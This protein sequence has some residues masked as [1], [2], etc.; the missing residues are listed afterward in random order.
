VNVRSVAALGAVLAILVLTVRPTPAQ[1]DAPPSFRSGVNAVRV[2]VIVTSGDGRPIADLEASD[3]EVFEDGTPQTI[4]SFEVVRVDGSTSFLQYAP[5]PIRS[6]ADEEVEAGRPD[7]GL[8]L[9]YFNGL[10]M[11]PNRAEQILEPLAQFVR[12]LPPGDMVGVMDPLTP[13]SAVMLT[14]DR[15]ATVAA[16]RAQADMAARDRRERALLNRESIQPYALDRGIEAASL[17]LASLREGRQA[18]ILI[19]SSAPS[20]QSPIFSDLVKLLNANNTAVHVVDP[21]GLVPG[22]SIFRGSDLQ[23]LAERTGGLAVT[24]TNAIQ[25]GLDRIAED[26]RVQYVLTYASPAPADGRFHEIAVR[27]R[28]P[29]ARVRARSGYLALSAVEMRRAAAPARPVDAS[30][31][32]ALATA[33]ST[34]TLV[35]TWVGTARGA[36]GAT[37]VTLAWEPVPAAPGEQRRQT[38]Q[39]A[40]VTATVRNGATVYDSEAPDGTAARVPIDSRLAQ[41]VTFDAPPG[42]LDVRLSLYAREEVV[43]SESRTLDV[44][45]YGRQPAMSTPAVHAGRSA[46]EI[47][48]IRSD[49][50]RPPVVRREFSRSEQL[51]VRFE[52]YG[53]DVKPRATLLNQSGERMHEIAIADSDEPDRYEITTGV[54]H[55]AIG[56]YV[57]EIALGDDE[58]T[59]ALVPIKVR[60]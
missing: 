34:A 16:I 9:L 36:N 56:D 12:S 47:R 49:P 24:R 5:S 43:D 57:L 27:V 20:T 40:S 32:S 11:P 38:P 3:F 45:D 59:R 4:D 10:Y 48:T 22:G 50:D 37:R 28:R 25:A 13:L 58:E 18:I 6:L 2:D 17:H 41:S 29:G 60:R 46:V 35:R 51:L 21:T 39:Q 31:Q 8:Y 30:V 23:E 44:P 19:S 1:Q 42:P 54:S 26:G 15:D 53:S 55:L 33:V 52:T 14:R 7:V